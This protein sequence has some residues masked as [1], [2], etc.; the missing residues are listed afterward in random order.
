MRH[1]DFRRE[2]RRKEQTEANGSLKPGSK[3]PYKAIGLDF[4]IDFDF[5]DPSHLSYEYLTGKLT[6]FGHLYMTYFSAVMRH[7]V[8]VYGVST[9]DG[10][11]VMDPNPEVKFTHRKLG[12]FQTMER[13][14]EWVTVGW[15]VKS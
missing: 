3:A 13:L 14:K 15:P 1:L 2:V 11:A 6:N 9:T 10:V 12:F 7:A 5:I 4:G 8:V